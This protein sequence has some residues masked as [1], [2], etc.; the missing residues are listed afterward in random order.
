MSSVVNTMPPCYD[1]NATVVFVAPEL[2][3]VFFPDIHYSNGLFNIPV[4]LKRV[5]LE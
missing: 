4:G 1:A 2:G 5:S 3:C